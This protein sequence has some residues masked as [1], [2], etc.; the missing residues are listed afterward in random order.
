MAETDDPISQLFDFAD[1]PET[2]ASGGTGGDTTFVFPDAEWVPGDM[3]GKSA[4]EVAEA[5]AVTRRELAK[6]NEALNAVTK[7]A[8]E[9]KAAASVAPG[10][11]DP[12]NMAIDILLESKVEKVIGTDPLL[13]KYKDE[14]MDLLHQIQDPRV[15]MTKDAMDM[16]VAQVRGSHYSEG[17]ELTKA[18]I[19]KTVPQHADASEAV[20]GV[21]KAPS[22]MVSVTP[23]RK[24]NL[25]AWFEG[26]LDAAKR[27]LL[28]GDQ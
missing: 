8:E 17:I 22:P 3:K 24:A 19:M 9:K 18:E 27:N 23:E 28:G 12:L 6:Q 20:G 4:K 26:D 14:V 16:V 21:Y 5:L 1:E 10:G 13:N 11:V 15:R 25:A 2:Q 7:I